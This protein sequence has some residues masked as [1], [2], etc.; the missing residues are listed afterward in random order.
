[1]YTRH[2][3]LTP[4][5]MRQA[6]AECV[7]SYDNLTEDDI[8]QLAYMVGTALI[9]R[10]RSL[11]VANVK[12]DGSYLGSCSVYAPGGH[13][14]YAAISVRFPNVAGLPAAILFDDDGTVLF[15]QGMERDTGEV[16]MLPVF[17]AFDEWVHELHDAMVRRALGVP[18]GAALRCAE[19]KGG[20]Q[21]E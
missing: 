19:G 6:F 8:Y 21:D 2:Y 14:K 7:G 3:D 5:G 20:G 10:N 13:V 18:D 11:G 12:L 1:M 9:R 15:G 4:E 17:K 16:L